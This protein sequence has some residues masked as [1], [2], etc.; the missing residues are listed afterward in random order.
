[1]KLED[2][3]PGQKINKTLIKMPLI[4]FTPAAMS[5]AA[6]IHA[7]DFT[8]SGKYFRIHITGKECDGFTYST[9][10]DQNLEEDFI[11]TPQFAATQNGPSSFEN[12][13]PSFK[14]VMDPFTAFYLQKAIVDF[15]IK[16][17][18]QEEGFFVNNLQQEDFEGKFWQADVKKIPPLNTNLKL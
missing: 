17:M 6:L 15:Q 1:M 12:I 14:V 9:F 10:F 16:P 3:L 8:L 2:I 7:H 4:F 11:L 5:Q 18:T 13:V